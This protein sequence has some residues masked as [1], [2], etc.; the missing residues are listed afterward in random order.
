M[1]LSLVAGLAL[2]LVRVGAVVIVAPVFGG[3]FAPAPVK[4]GLTLAITLV[5]VPLVPLPGTLTVA[6]LVVVALREAMIGVAIGFGVRVVVAAAE[7]GGY[8]AGYQLGFAQAATID[9]QS[10]VR[11]NTI[12][13][14]YG[15]LATLIFFAV[16]GH[17]LVLRALLQ[18]YRRLPVGFGQVDDGVVPVVMAMLGTVFVTGAQLAA[19][20]VVV[21]L[22]LEAG[23]GLL[24]RA[25][26]GV[27]LFA[28]TPPMRL[29]VG[30]AALGTGIVAVPEVM[31]GL[32]RR[33]L[34][35]AARLALGVG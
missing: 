12:A 29:L 18:S 1:D 27:D 5:L 7:M 4:I 19:P 15:N 17:H 6:G 23:L 35:L 22:V 25:A 28:L 16:N 2:I 3:T 13:L 24:G 8:L 10:G 21:M 11:N 9:P 26:S 33:A 31:S 14:I 20:V 32:I 30:L 34:E